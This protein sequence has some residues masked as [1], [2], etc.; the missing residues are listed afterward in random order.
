MTSLDLYRFF[1]LI[2][3]LFINMSFIIDFDKYIS[4]GT[5]L[6][7]N[8]AKLSFPIIK[9]RI[10]S[11]SPPL[12]P[13]PPEFNLYCSQGY[14]RQLGRK[15]KQHLILKNVFKLKVCLKR[16]ILSS[17]Q[18]VEGEWVKETLRDVHSSA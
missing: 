8:P 10:I 3:P 15:N 7:S 12:L 9:K 16:R 13:P 4:N 5:S 17:F 14:S 1:L 11:F 18:K 6:R 2:Y